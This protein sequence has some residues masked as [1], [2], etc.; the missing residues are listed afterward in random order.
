MKIKC[1]EIVKALVDINN[2]NINVA[3]MLWTAFSYIDIFSFEA[4]KE[5]QS[6]GKSESEAIIDIL[7]DFYQ[8][9]R[10][11]LDNVRIM[12][13][14]FLNNLKKL[15]PEQYLNNPYVKAVTTEGKRG[16]YALKYFNYAPYQLFAYDEIKVDYHYQEMSSI[17]YFVKPFSYLALTQNDHIW[18]SL[19]P[20]EIETMK[21]FIKNGK[22]NV[23]TLGLG[24]GYFPY[25]LALKKEV[26]QI[27]I[28]EQ[29]PHIIKIFNE[30]ILP[31][32]TNA[33]KI[34]IIKDE[35]LAYLRKNK[36]GQ[37][38]DYIF[39][40][41]WHNPVDGLQTFIALKKLNLNIECWLET[42]FIALLRRQMII[43]LEE[44]LEGK[45]DNAY[46]YAKTYGDKMINHFYHKT[47]DLV[48]ETAADVENLLSSENLLKLAL[49]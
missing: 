34:T 19:N 42:S 41:L 47:K 6:L 32:F 9:N 46:R 48:L 35:A 26:K 8:L 21:P 31:S 29:D 49:N 14:Y 4:I 40:D 27:T 37:H 16:Q 1:R 2:I 25:M 11:D 7:Y 22:G 44:Q 23:L 12:D 39:A 18:M 33:H 20:N 45:G 38:Y 10:D 36:K 24:M 3:D 30:L 15:D 13:L 28:I 5:L 43:L 17:G